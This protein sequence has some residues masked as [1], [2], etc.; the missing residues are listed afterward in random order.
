MYSTLSDFG[1]NIIVE[2]PNGYETITLFCSPEKLDLFEVDFEKEP[3]YTIEPDD[4]ERL[5]Q[6]LARLDQLA[7]REWVGTS[8]Q[9]RIGPKTKDL[10]KKFGALPPIDV[11]GTA[12]KF[13][14]P[15][16]STGT[17]GKQ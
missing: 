6:L 12:G 1:I 4:E 9:I 5:R 2:P 3:F 17:T 11:S 16:E 14:P 8:V 13:F 10:P 15:I 7:E